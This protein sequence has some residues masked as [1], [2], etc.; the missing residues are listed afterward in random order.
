MPIPNSQVTNKT[1]IY[2]SVFSIMFTG[3]LMLV[4]NE[5]SN[6]ECSQ[7]MVVEL[8]WFPSSNQHVK[9]RQQRPMPLLRWDPVTWNLE[10]TF[11]EHMSMQ[12]DMQI[13]QITLT[14]RLGVSVFYLG[15]S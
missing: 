14:F 6:F 3:K 10:Y 11:L 9:S 5:I 8:G 7:F 2:V 12:R 1:A 4:W 13:K 15:Q